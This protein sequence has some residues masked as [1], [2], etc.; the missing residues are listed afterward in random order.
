MTEQ[1]K[2]YLSSKFWIAAIAMG[3]LTYIYSYAMQLGVKVPLEFTGFL[4]GIAGSFGI[5]KT[6]QNVKLTN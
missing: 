6:Y 2:F 1:S 5:F 3:C 4:T